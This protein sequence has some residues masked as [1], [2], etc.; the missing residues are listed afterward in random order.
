MRWYCLE[1]NH[2]DSCYIGK[3]SYDGDD[4]EIAWD[5]INEGW[6]NN[7]NSCHL[8]SQKAFDELKESMNKLGGK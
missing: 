5:E 7:L 8:L 2:S 4:D 6:Q 1:I 3:L